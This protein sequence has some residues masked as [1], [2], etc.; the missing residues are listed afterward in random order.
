MA[1]TRKKKVEEPENHER[2]LVSYADFITLLFAFFVVMYAISSVNEGKYRVLSDTMV[3]AFSDQLKEQPQME[4]PLLTT[5][6]QE[7]GML[8]RGEDQIIQQQETGTSLIEI[9]E[10]PEQANEPTPSDIEPTDDR[11]WVVASNLDS[12]LQG[13]I[14]QKLV[15][16]NLQGD[17]IEVQFS[18]KLLFGSG[19]ARL[20]PEARKAFRDIAVIVKPLK[21]SIFVEGHTDNV[22]I[23]TLAFPSNWELSAARAASVVEYLTR[24]EL[25]PRRLAAIGY[26]EY[27]PISSND[28]EEGRSK[29]RRVTLVLRSGQGSNPYGELGVESALPDQADVPWAESPGGF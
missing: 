20:S 23:K 2:W 13:F 8:E 26:G 29:N 14:D 9:G 24:Q 27:R 7:G 19:S 6:Q 1:R 3:E 12:S 18:S 10:Y 5:D 21:N 4:A 17:K 28:N 25:D 16:V 15:K 22:P 11:L